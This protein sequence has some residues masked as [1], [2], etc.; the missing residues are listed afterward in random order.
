MGRS[1]LTSRVTF[2]TATPTKRDEK[3]NDH[4]HVCTWEKERQ[5]ARADRER[6]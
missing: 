3:G 2:A 6:D 1:Q 5:A 4:A